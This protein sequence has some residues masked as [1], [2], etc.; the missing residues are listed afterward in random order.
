MFYTTRYV[1]H[2]WLLAYWSV[3]SYRNHIHILIS[4]HSNIS[5]HT[6]VYRWRDSINLTW[7]QGTV[8]YSNSRRIGFHICGQKV[9]TPW[10][11]HW[12][13]FLFLSVHWGSSASWSPK[14]TS[15]QISKIS[16]AVKDTDCGYKDMFTIF[17]L[18]L[19]SPQEVEPNS[20]PTYE[21]NLVICF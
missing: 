21:I 14:Y 19:L 3:Q 10:T 18:L 16:E 1:K 12:F 5:R 2:T 13:L 7:K 8:K 20:S 11:S 6:T 15:I 17:F 9:V 4:P